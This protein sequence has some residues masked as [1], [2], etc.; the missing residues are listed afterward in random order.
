MSDPHRPAVPD[1]RSPK[2]FVGQALTFIG[3]AKQHS[4]ERWTE[5]RWQAKAKAQD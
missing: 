1:T 4:A 5:C 2:E 3:R